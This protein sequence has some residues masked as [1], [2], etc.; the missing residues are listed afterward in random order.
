MA[1]IKKGRVPREMEDK[2]FM[3]YSNSRLHIHRSWTG[4]AI[5]IV[6]F[7]EEGDEATAVDFQANVDPEQYIGADGAR[8]D[9][10]QQVTLLILSLTYRP[11]LLNQCCFKLMLKCCCL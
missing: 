11:S 3:Y 9:I 6:R 5:Y 2:W 1:G 10:V 8:D 7:I 4:Y